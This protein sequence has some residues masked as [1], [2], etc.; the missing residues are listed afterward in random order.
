MFV[1]SLSEIS[2][3]IVAKCLTEGSYKHLD[4][5]LNASLSDQVFSKLTELTDYNYSPVIA[6]ETGL[7]LNLSNFDTEGLPVSREDLVNL[8]RH[9]IRSLAIGLVKIFHVPEYRIGKNRDQIDIERVLK[10]CLNERSRQNL[11][12]LSCDFFECFPNGWSESI[13]ELLPNLL[14]FSPVGMDNLTGIGHLKNLQILTFDDSSFDSTEQLKDVFELPNLRVL[15]IRYCYSFFETLLFCN[16][17]FQNLKLIDCFDSEITETQLRTLVERNPSLETISLLGTPCDYTDFSD[18]SVTVLNLATI[19]STMNSLGYK[20]NQKFGC[21]YRWEVVMTVNRLAVLLETEG[22]FK[23]DEF[24]KLMMKVTQKCPIFGG[25]ENGVAKCLI[26][27]FKR[28]FPDQSMAEILQK[29]DPRDP[30]FVERRWAAQTVL[31]LSR[32]CPFQSNLS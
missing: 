20:L 25:E 28:F 22:G 8:S 23:E 11:R 2:S 30:L 31:I 27:Y 6:K 5:N 3:K 7:K 29:L 26:Q 13:G 10:T 19:Q 12:H 18:L 9:E 17:T 4:I 15:N 1:D 32:A 14:S 16:G 24:L 21:S